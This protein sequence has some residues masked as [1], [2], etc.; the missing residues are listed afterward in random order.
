MISSGLCFLL[1]IRR[2]FRGPDYHSRWTTQTGAAQGR[3]D[4]YSDFGHTF[5]PKLG[6]TFKVVEGLSIRGNWGTSFTAPTPLDQL[7]SLQ[8]TIS[9]Y[10]FVAFTR[11]GDSTAPGSYTL[12]LQGSVPGLKP[13][14]AHTWSVG[15]DATPSIIPGLRASFSYY[16]VN[17]RDILS[18]PVVNSQIFANYPSNITTNVAGLSA[19]QLLAFEALAPNGAA[20]IAPLIGTRTV[21]EFVDFRT[22][23]FGVLKVSGLDMSASY[24]HPASFGGFDLAANANYQ[25]KRDS[26]VSPTSSVVD[27]LA[28]DNGPR[29][30]LQ[31]IG[32]V[33]IGGLRAQATWNHSGGYNIT[34]TLSVPVQNHIG[35]FNVVNLF[36]KYDIK[37]DSKLLQ[38][39]SFTLNVNNV[40]D[41]APPVSYLTGPADNGYANGFTLG[42]MFVIGA[43]KKF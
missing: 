6:A 24:Q 30:Q 38:D 4:D 1:G 37:N 42:R 36:F 31:V 40:F 19:A 15:F 12:G 5:N 41:A 13:Q 2:P 39:L 29:L 11:P 33:N 28:A 3:Y 26:Q 21:Y 23:N 9:A 43:A 7:G 17:F 34:P 35:V 18:T 16:H 8:N 10:P 14:K 20:V 27:Q 22:A 32:G 25:L